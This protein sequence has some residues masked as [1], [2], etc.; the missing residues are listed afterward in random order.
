MINNGKRNVF[1]T[2][3]TFYRMS[4][5]QQTVF[6]KQAVIC[7]V[8]PFTFLSVKPTWSLPRISDGLMFVCASL[9]V[10]GHATVPH[11]GPAHCAFHKLFSL[12]FHTVCPSFVTAV[13]VVN[14]QQPTLFTKLKQIASCTNSFNASGRQPTPPYINEWPSPLDY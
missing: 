12:F 4:K 1:T 9:N 7:F 5:A 11:L 14:I 13:P 2:Q 6:G 3:K 10:K 8:I